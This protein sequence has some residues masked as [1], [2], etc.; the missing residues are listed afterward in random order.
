MKV[1]E[2]PQDVLLELVKQLNLRYVLAFLSVYFNSCGRSSLKRG[3]DYM[4]LHTFAITTIRARHYQA[5]KN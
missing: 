1:G 3:K 2:V 4:G 5:G